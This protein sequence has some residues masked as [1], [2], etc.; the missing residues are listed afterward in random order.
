MRA[1]AAAAAERVAAKGAQDGVEA[2]RAVLL[3]P[4]HWQGKNLAF[5]S[6]WRVCEKE[7]GGKRMFICG[8]CGF[9]VLY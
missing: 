6:E 3:P 5:R 8:V 4:R 7:G 9:R 2:L 1:A